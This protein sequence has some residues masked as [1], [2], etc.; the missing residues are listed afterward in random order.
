M[1]KILNKIIVEYF[2][3]H[4][5]DFDDIGIKQLKYQKDAVQQGLEIINKYDGCIIA[6]VVGLGKTYVSLMIAQRLIV[7]NNAESILIVL[8]PSNEVNWADS[9]NTFKSIKDKITLIS[10][11]QLNKLKSSKY[12]VVIVD[13]SHNFRNVNTQKYK[14]LIKLTKPSKVML[15]TATPIQ[16]SLYDLYGQLALFDKGHLIETEVGKTSISLNAYFKKY[17]NK[18]SDVL[19]NK[20]YSVKEKEEKLKFVFQEIKDK[21]VSKIMIRR[22]RTNLSSIPEYKDDLD[23][24]GIIF[25]VINAP[26]R[27]EYTYDF[28][29]TVKNTLSIIKNLSFANYNPF[30]YLIPVAKIAIER[31]N[32]I[33][34]EN[35]SNAID[36][37]FKIILL[38]R[39][40]SSIYSFKITINKIIGKI[41][42]A[43]NNYDNGVLEVSDD[44][45]NLT[46]KSKIEKNDLI[47]DYYSDLKND[48]H[49]LTSIVD[50]WNKYK[51][52]NKVNELKKILLNLKNKVVIFSESIDTIDYLTKELSDFKVLAVTSL[53]RKTNKNVII[54]EFDANCDKKTNEFDILLTSD[55]LSEGVNLHRAETIINFDIT[56]NPQRVVQRIGRLDRIGSIAPNISI[57]NFLS[58]SVINSEIY[59]N[60]IA[61]NKINLFNSLLGAD[62]KT[63]FED[64]E[65]QSFNFFTTENEND[66]EYTKELELRN[67]LQNI[68][69]DK[70]DEIKK[71]M[72]IQ[73]I[74]PKT[75]NILFDNLLVKYNKFLID[76]K[77][78]LRKDFF[79]SLQYK[80]NMSDIVSELFKMERK[81][82]IYSY[83]MISMLKNENEVKTFAIS[84]INKR[85]LYSYKNMNGFN[86]KINDVIEISVIELIN[87]LDEI[88]SIEK[89]EKS[90]NTRDVNDFILIRDEYLKIIEFYNNNLENAI[91][92]CDKKSV[93]ICRFITYKLSEVFIANTT[94]KDKYIKLVSDEVY[95]KAIEVRNYLELGYYPELLQEVKQVL[96]NDSVKFISDVSELHDRYPF[97]QKK[98]KTKEIQEL[99][100]LTTK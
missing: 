34:I 95:Q 72:I 9:V 26:I 22:T 64:E 73:N 17:Q 86:F 40:D 33:K 66:D 99:L 12:S 16:N 97:I 24:Q 47:P 42:T 3:K 14:Q 51:T 55:T 52:D 5:F 92:L 69:D 93:D 100:T 19:E 23:K 58:S 54:T 13:E 88:N 63:L 70:I 43:I 75:L 94:V 11:H 6:D 56:W 91:V 90:N 1:E 61:K 36:S 57:Y 44:D 4:K 82:A 39:L 96:S 80:I 37:L 84:G 25:P 87:L 65:I 46:I 38:K 29:D 32:K 60:E 2:K 62:N 8:S 68:S 77:E 20:L 53:N 59:I 67:K 71:D 78:E 79:H 15:L 35:I 31:E 45:V 85:D 27:V 49:L 98:Y 76:N 7:E 89:I 18:I 48:L 81:L 21:L 50:D 83:K 10:T 30:K 41:K 28:E 74:N